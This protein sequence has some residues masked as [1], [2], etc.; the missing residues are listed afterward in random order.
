VTNR[1]LSPRRRILLGVGLSVLALTQAMIGGWALFAPA[2]FFSSFPSAGHPWAALLPPY[3]EHLVRDVGALSL[4]LTVVLVAAAVTADRLLARVALAAFA[5]YAVPH[6]IFHSLHLEHFAQADAVA[7][8]S[9]FVAQLALIVA[10]FIV[11]L[12]RRPTTE[13]NP[14]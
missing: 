13:V 4:A 11:T 7:Q 12:D 3:N 10:L 6:T 14:A 9:G 2:G 8:M 1:G 5:T